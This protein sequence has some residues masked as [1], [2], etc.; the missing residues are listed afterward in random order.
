MKMVWKPVKD[1]HISIREFGEKFDGSPSYLTLLKKIEEG[2]FKDYFAL[3]ESD[4]YAK[5]VPEE[6]VKKLLDDYGN[7]HEFVKKVGINSSKSR[8]ETKP[9]VV[10]KNPMQAL[11]LAFKDLEN[12]PYIDEKGNLRLKYTEPNGSAES[13]ITIDLFGPA[14]KKIK[15]I[16]KSYT[17]L[18]EDWEDIL[19]KNDQ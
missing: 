15:D 3:F 19:K 1:G 12:T 14:I 6:G 4:E 2:M 8:K 9:A 11:T 7:Y 5:S 18:A 13:T 16:G 10:A 17:D